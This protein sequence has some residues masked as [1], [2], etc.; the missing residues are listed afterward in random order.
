MG[1]VSRIKA[2]ALGL[3]DEKAWNPSLWRLIGSQS[4]TGEVVNE[5]T[6]LTYSAVWNAVTLIS[7]T[8]ASL[9]LHL[10]VQRG[11]KKRIADNHATYLTLHDAAN[12]YMISKV[13][14]ETLMAHVLTW[15]NGFAEKVKNR[16]GEVVQLWPIAP[17][18][19]TPMW[20]GGQII[21]RI[22]VDNQDKYF[23][24]DKILHIA[25]LGYDGL[26]G[27]SVVSMAR[28]SIALGMAMETF[29]SNYFGHGTHPGVIVSHPGQLGKDSYEN[30]K[31]NL[32]EA[33]SGLGQSHRLMLLEDGLKLESVT[34]PPEDSQ[35][36]QS[37]Q[38]QVPEIARW[39]NLPPHKLKDLSRSSFCLPAEEEVFTQGGPKRIADVIAGEKVWSLADKSRW[40]LSDVVKSAVTGIDEIYTIKT[41]NRTVRCNAKHPIL[42]RRRRADGE[43]IT[44]W[45][46]AGELNV[47]D[48]IVTVRGL[49]ESKKAIPT[50]ADGS[51]IT[52]PF[53]EFCG[54]L[55]G[56]GNVMGKK[57]KPAVISISRAKDAPY[58]DYYRDVAKSLF[59]VG[60]YEYRR[61]IT[62][63][64]ARL[65][66][67]DVEEIRKNGRLVLTNS[68][69]ARRYGANICAIQNIIHREYHPEHPQAGL[70]KQQVAEIKELLR[71]RLTT[72]QIADEYGVSRDTIVK[73][74]SGRLWSGRKKT[75]KVRPVNLV[76]DCRSTAFT[77]AT[78]AEEL[79]SLGFGGTSATKS[80]PEWVF[81]TP[82]EL[83]LAFLRGFLDS[84]GSVCRK[85]RAAFS[86]CN[87]KLLSQM[88]H[89]CLG[90]GI[91][92]TNLYNRKG[93][94]NLPDGRR[95]K[96]SQFYFTCSD[97]GSNRRI[98]SHTPIYNERFNS[99]NPFSKK[100]RNYPKFG[101]AGFDISGCSLARVTSIEK[102]L[103]LQPV[104]DLCVKD[105][106]SFVANGVVVHNSNIESEQRSFYTDTLLPWLVTLEQNFNY[107]L[108]SE[109]DRQ[110]KYYF[111]H[112]AEGILRADAAGRGEFYSKMFNIG[113]YS[114]NEI[115]ALEDKDPVEGGDVHL[116]PLHMTT[117]EN[118]GKVAGDRGNG[119][120]RFDEPA[121]AAPK[122]A[123]DVKKMVS[124]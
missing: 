118:A 25:G 70:N 1:I 91:P 77:S 44:S 54:L 19:V 117:L 47:G 75:S 69:I 55:I 5:D 73:I 119:L 62:H 58:M 116:V 39:F 65:N 98:G 79:I 50:R 111:K 64:G 101:G 18:K 38:F 14:R 72:Q 52:V 90:L 97:P 43:W 112:N 59:T 84:A 103:I 31:K 60:G 74:L 42:T 80:V 22:R 57:G 122:E 45:T 17:D 16:A 24:R 9:P 76:E 104:Y 36:L 95:A 71:R 29:G 15:G 67:Q 32:T 87:K 63:P 48:T 96:F 53:M 3:N 46:P 13:F 86:S 37:R 115:R 10:M 12:P 78:G 92:V 56:A 83:R 109:A 99:G 123:E 68:E 108:L 4:L 49:P 27:Y 81:E 26:M 113:A 88:R 110:R 35:F 11:E 6:A 34:I 33:Y 21:Y 30:L 20:D 121:I 28:K 66:E 102:D 82:E 40:V 89:L 61:G 7:G 51:P 41:T 2:M 93:I 120:D 85:G 94:A 8:I 114:I 124:N 100:D 105:T 23:T 107:Q 106:H